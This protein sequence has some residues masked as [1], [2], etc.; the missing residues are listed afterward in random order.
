VNSIFA[1]LNMLAVGAIAAAFA[2]MGPALLFKGRAIREWLVQFYSNDQ[3]TDHLRSPG[4]LLSMR[5]VGAG[6][7]GIELL[8]LAKSISLLVSR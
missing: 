1:F 7:V 2:A 5:L 4:Y 8:M 6:V 3:I